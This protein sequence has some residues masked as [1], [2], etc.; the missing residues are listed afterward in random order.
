MLFK[1]ASTLFRVK[2]IEFRLNIYIF[3]LIT[4]YTIKQSKV[5]INE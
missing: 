4:K 2:K 1:K 3:N 5:C